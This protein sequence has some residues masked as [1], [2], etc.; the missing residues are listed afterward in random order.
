[1]ATEETN[2]Q[3]PSGSAEPLSGGNLR[4][5]ATFVPHVRIPWTDGIAAI[6]QPDNMIWRASTPEEVWIEEATA[7]IGEW[8]SLARSVYLRWALTINASAKAEERYRALPV[9]QALTTS[10]LRVLDG[11]PRQVEI[12]RWPAAQ[13]AEHYAAI[14][15]LIAAYGVADL[16]GALEDIIFDF[17]EIVLRH[18]PESL[19]RG[20]EYR[21]LRRLRAQRG[22]SPDAE[23]AWRQAWAQRFTTWRRK[24]AYDGLPDVLVALYRHAGLQRPTQY[25]RTD[26]ADWARSLEMIGELRHHVVHGAATVSDRLGAL[27]GTANALTFDFVTGAALDVRL[28]HLQSVECFSDQLLSAFNLSLMERVLGPLRDVA[29]RPAGR[30]GQRNE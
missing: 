7:K 28:H 9:D 26:V 3:P 23:N 4:A 15:P 30:K 20:D 11:A 16:Y 13:A 12:A 25:S 29:R 21:P 10:T 19:L 14:T 27:S 6:V 17:Y 5:R 1:M 2:A 22:V 24:R 8:R 18:N